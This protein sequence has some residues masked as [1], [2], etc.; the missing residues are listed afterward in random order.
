MNVVGKFGNL[1][2]K[3]VYSVAT[4][5]H[6][7]GGAVDVIVVQQQDGTFRSTPWYVRFGKFQGVLKGAEKIVKINVNGVEANFHMYLDNSGEAY[8]VK[9]V[10]EDDKESE[11]NVAA[12]AATNF[13]SLT[14]GS[15][16]KIDYENLSVD[17]ITGHRLEHTVSDPGVLQLKGEDCSSVLPK[18]QKAESD[19]GRRFYDFQDDQPTIEG[20]ADLLE[21]GSSQYDNLDGEN[22]VDLQGSLPEVVL[23][24]VDGHILTAPISESEQTEENLQLKIPQFHLGPGEGTEFYEGN[25]EFST[26]EDACSTDYVSQLDAS[27]A[28]DK[29]KKK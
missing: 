6:P 28:D 23:V 21:Y 1:I 22:F 10:D 14:E 9:E 27:T 8:F 17:D 12:E 2:T 15:G 3:G 20:S 13:E 18:L 29:Y 7:F 25:E 24:S 26:G 16:V 11:S 19:I 4:P 5:F